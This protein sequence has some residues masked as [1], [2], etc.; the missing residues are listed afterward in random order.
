[1]FIEHFD[2]HNIDNGDD[3]DEGI[4]ACVPLEGRGG[5]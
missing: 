1:M 5:C 3:N 4:F 2:N